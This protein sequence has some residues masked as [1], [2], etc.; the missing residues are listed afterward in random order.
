[1]YIFKEYLLGLS[2]FQLKYGLKILILSLQLNVRE[3]AVQWAVFATPPPPPA[4]PPSHQ[5]VII[6][7]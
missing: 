1:M 4:P 5:E 7:I 6:A 2:Y 3:R